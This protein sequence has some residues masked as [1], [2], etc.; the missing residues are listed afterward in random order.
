[1]LERAK[2]DETLNDSPSASVEGLTDSYETS[3]DSSSASVEGLT[4][5]QTKPDEMIISV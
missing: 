3:T 1:M 5:S 2:I 4:D